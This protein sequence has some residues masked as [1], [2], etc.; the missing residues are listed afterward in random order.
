MHVCSIAFYQEGGRGVAVLS[1]NETAA[2]DNE[3]TG[4]KRGEPENRLHLRLE[5]FRRLKNERRTWASSKD[6]HMGKAKLEPEL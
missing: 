2:M 4:E 1:S 3:S 6:S 5:I